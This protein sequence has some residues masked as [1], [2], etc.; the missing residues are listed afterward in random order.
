[1]E[2]N[3][4]DLSQRRTEA[5]SVAHFLEF[6]GCLVRTSCVVVTCFPNAQSLRPDEVVEARLIFTSPT[7]PFLSGAR[8]SR[9]RNS[10]FPGRRALFLRG[11]TVEGLRPESRRIAQDGGGVSAG[12]ARRRGQRHRHGGIADMPCPRR[13]TV[14]CT[15]LGPARRVRYIARADV[16]MQ[17]RY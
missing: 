9:R 6:W 16:A 2:L 10:S 15:I 13:Y 17:F 1:M 7:C 8:G 14:V 5:P 11:G 4:V 3:S 12:V